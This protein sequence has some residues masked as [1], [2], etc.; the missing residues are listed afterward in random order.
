MKTQAANI[1]GFPE[2]GN[3][4]LREEE[5]GECC[6]QGAIEEIKYSLQN[7]SALLPGA[8]K[9]EKAIKEKDELLRE[10]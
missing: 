1:Y 10:A 9:E 8:L 3:A 2:E 4:L 7:E 5:A 6:Q